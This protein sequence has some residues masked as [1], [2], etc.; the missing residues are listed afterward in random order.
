MDSIQIT[1]ANELIN[2]GKFKKAKKILSSCKSDKNALFLLSKCY[3]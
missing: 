1:A 2:Q 3:K